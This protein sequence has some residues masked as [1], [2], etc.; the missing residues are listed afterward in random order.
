V[1]EWQLSFC[2]DNGCAAALLSFFE[3]W[4]NV[5]RDMLVKNK[6]LNDIADAQ[7]E[8]R[9][10]DETLYQ[11]HTQDDLYEGI[12]KLYGKT[13]IKEA[14]GYL[15]DKKTIT[16]HGNPN[17]RYKFDRTVFYQFHPDVCNAWLSEHYF[18]NETT[19]LSSGRIRPVDESELTNRLVAN[20]APSSDSDQCS[21]VSD[22]WCA[23]SDQTITEIT[24]KIT[25]EITDRE[26]NNINNKKNNGE[27]VFKKNT[28]V[29]RTKPLR[30]QQQAHGAAQT[31]DDKPNQL[32][33]PTWTEKILPEVIEQLVASG[34]SRSEVEQP[35][36]VAWLQIKIKQLLKQR[37]YVSGAFKQ[38]LAFSQG[39]DDVPQSMAELRELMDVILGGCSPLNEPQPFKTIRQ[40]TQA[41][42]LGGIA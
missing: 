33:Q 22:Q 6:R 13:K 17:P 14:L 42:E 36:H 11:Y 25:T 21:A 30:Q 16:R 34:F 20:C 12:M 41:A 37:R 31:T 8:G 19:N 38:A 4:H 24:T 23:D 18:N 1:R 28:E 10:Q 3:Y 26:K 27:L 2:E 9:V 15:V 29:P 7:G 32:P 39:L 40:H 5:K 35:H